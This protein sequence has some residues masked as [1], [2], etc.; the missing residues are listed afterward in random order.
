MMPIPVHSANEPW[1]Q[2][3]LRRADNVNLCDAEGELMRLPALWLS[4]PKGG[5]PGSPAGLVVPELIAIGPDIAVELEK[6]R[7]A[8]L[9]AK[10]ASTS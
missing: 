1:A 8:V 9:R 10:H 2:E 7:E 3:R 5:R 4:P 6:A